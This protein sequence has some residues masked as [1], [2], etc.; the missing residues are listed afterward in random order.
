MLK[1]WVLGCDI[2]IAPGGIT[3][4]I[5]KIHNKTPDIPSLV[6]YDV[7]KNLIGSLIFFLQ[8]W[9]SYIWLDFG[10]ILN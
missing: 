1:F 2:G 5:I 7:I 9:I 3:M 4:N 10:Q 8:S 6:H